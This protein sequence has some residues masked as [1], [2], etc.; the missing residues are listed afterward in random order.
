MGVYKKVPLAQC[1][2]ETGKKPIGI[3][4]STRTKATLRAL[5]FDLG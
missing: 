5:V 3:G 1:F 4:G 2:V